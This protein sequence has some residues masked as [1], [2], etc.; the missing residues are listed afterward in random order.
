[1]PIVALG[2]T[3]TPG[4]TSPGWRPGAGPP[5]RPASA[6]GGPCPRR[7]PPWPGPSCGPRPGGPCRGGPWLSASCSNPQRALAEGR[8]IVGEFMWDTM[9][10]SHGIGRV[11]YA[12][13]RRRLA[14]NQRTVLP[15]PSLYMYFLCHSH[16]SQLGLHCRLDSSLRLEHLCTAGRWWQAC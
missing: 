15:W 11:W 4:G 5:A 10:A 14:N 12:P 3:R 7:R 9:S 2:R 6:H 1:M 8:A 13:P 16:G